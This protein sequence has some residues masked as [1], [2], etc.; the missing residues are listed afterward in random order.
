MNRRYAKRMEKIKASE[1]REILKVTESEDI[2]SFA[3]GLPAPELFPVNE[4][5]VVSKLVL[6]ESGKQALQYTTTEGLE[7]LREHITKRMN[8]KYC[9]DLDIHSIQ[10]VSGS[11]QALDMSGKLFLDKDD[12]VV[13]ENPTYLG[14]INAFKAYDC[15]FATVE[16]DDEGIKIEDLKEVLE[17][18]QNVKFIYVIPD[19]HNPTGKSWSIERRVAFMEVMNQYDIPVIEDNPYGEIT[20]KD[21]IMPSL[22]CFDSKE[23]VITLG[24]FSKIFCP[25]LRIGW[26]AASRDIIEKYTLIKQSMD[27]HTSNISQREISKYLDLYHIDEH[28]DVIKKVYKRRRD[29]A[30]QTMDEKFPSCFK[31]TI[32]EG[33]LFTWVVGPDKMDAV[34]VLEHCL[35]NG[36]AFVPGQSFYPNGGGYNTFRLNF[37][38]ATEEQLITGL[39]SLG[40]VLEAYLEMIH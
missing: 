39:T 13:C 38:N 23:I 11:Q 36:V 1:I 26:I 40:A 30:I 10:I 24:T 27:L 21:T 18:E 6:E 25:G 19:F 2:I 12:V 14:A 22:K 9:L 16:T 28:I 8:A 33:G 34:E 31:F 17:S 32:P 5:K 35:V 29:I 4:M 37:S 7:S 15:R 20:F 3:G